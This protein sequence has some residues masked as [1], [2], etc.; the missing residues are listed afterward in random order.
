MKISDYFITPEEVR[1]LISA[2]GPF[3]NRWSVFAVI[4][5]WMIVPIFC[6]LVNKG[7]LSNSMDNVYVA[8]SA[9]FLF[10]IVCPY[11]ISAL[12]RK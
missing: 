10:C 9:V 12:F 6:L 1:G 7:I 3:N 5:G 8:T 4:F 2:D 11:L